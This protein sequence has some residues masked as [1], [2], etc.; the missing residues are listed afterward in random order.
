VKIVDLEGI[1]REVLEK[2]NFSL[3]GTAS[4]IDGF[5]FES[6]KFRGTVGTYGKDVSVTSRGEFLNYFPVMD[7]H[8]FTHK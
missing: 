5:G 7:L 6:R 8:P 1:L 2:V 3:K 4:R